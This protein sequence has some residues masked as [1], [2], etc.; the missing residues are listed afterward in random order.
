MTLLTLLLS[1]AFAAYAAVLLS[2]NTRRRIERMGSVP[3]VGTA[4]ICGAA[5]WQLGARV[6]HT[7]RS[8]PVVVLVAVPTK[9]LAQATR[10]S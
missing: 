5:N 3:A 2:M 8:L 1:T 7:R 6:Q 10:G 4:A 9:L